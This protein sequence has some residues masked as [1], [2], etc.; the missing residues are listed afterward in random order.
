MC[1]KDAREDEPAYRSGDE[2]VARTPPWSEREEARAG[3]PS[4]LRTNG[5][6]SE[7]TPVFRVS[8]IF[9][10]SRGGRDYNSISAPK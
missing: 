4:G 8:K 1:K 10:D 6:C 2:A 3:W 9:Y 7:I 5:D